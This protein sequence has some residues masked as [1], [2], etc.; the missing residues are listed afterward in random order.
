MSRCSSNPVLKYSA[1]P[2]GDHLP[3]DMR[4]DSKQH[5]SRLMCEYW[6]VDSSTYLCYIGTQSAV[7]DALLS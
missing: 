4:S 6:H 7:A 2:P 5:T 1:G 3:G